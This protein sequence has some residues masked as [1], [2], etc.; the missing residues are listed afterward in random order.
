MLQMCDV[1]E[2]QHMAIRSM[3][4]SSEH[5]SRRLHSSCSE[6]ALKILLRSAEVASH[7]MKR[8]CWTALKLC[9]GL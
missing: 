1:L 5:A 3:L 9:A 4:S 2:E 8:A 7:D 6:L